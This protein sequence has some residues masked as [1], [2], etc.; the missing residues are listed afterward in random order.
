MVLIKKYYKNKKYCLFTL[1]LAIIM[2]CNI[3]F[4]YINGSYYVFGSGINACKNS[5]I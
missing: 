3:R 2:G 5:D 1:F 4:R